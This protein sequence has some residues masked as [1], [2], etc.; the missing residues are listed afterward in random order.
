MSHGGG[1]CPYCG[2]VFYSLFEVRKHITLGHQGKDVPEWATE[3]CHLGVPLHREC[4]SI[5]CD[6]ANHDHYD[7]RRP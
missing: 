4:G 2:K 3:K 5:N 7:R 1:H 6:S